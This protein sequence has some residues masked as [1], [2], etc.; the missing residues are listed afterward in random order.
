MRRSRFAGAVKTSDRDRPVAWL[1]TLSFDLRHQTTSDDSVIAE[2]RIAQLDHVPLLLGVAHLISSAAILLH[3]G[4]DVPSSAAPFLIGPFLLA[5]LVDVA[6]FLFMRARPRIDVS[7]RIVTLVMCVLVFASCSLWS[8][9]GHVASW[10]PNSNESGIVPIVVG[11]VIVAS[12]VAVSSSPPLA[13]VCA[14]VGTVGAAIFSG[15][16]AVV[17]G[18]GTMAM[19]L[20]GYSVGSAR[21]MIATARERLLL[22]HEAHK[23][24]H[25]VNEF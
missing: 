6:A 3:Y 24:L 10:L 13:V 1:D 11:T 17:G 9:F 18:I 8:L 16:P 19:V 22:D 21:T 7:A 14:F 2:Q 12:A 15:D 20:V 5:L 4:F 25:F 23:A